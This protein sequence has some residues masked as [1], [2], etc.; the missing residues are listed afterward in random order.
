[1]GPTDALRHALS[2]ANFARRWLMYRIC[3][4]RDVAM[5]CRV[6]N[7]EALLNDDSIGVEPRRRVALHRIT[8]VRHDR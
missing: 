2:W 1:M 6:R 7:V 4:W 5:E 3:W 8:A